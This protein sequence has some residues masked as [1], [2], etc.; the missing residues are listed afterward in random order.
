MS[1]REQ[2]GQM[3]REYRRDI[4]QLAKVQAELDAKVDQG[5]AALEKRLSKVEADFTSLDAAFL[6]I[7]LQFQGIRDEFGALVGE[8]RQIRADL[9]ESGRTV[10]GRLRLTEER[11][12]KMLDLVE[13]EL[14]D[15][16][17]EMLVRI[18]AL[19]GRLPPA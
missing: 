2:I 12:N 1:F 4:G 18:E 6:K 11:L 7:E 8:T 17:A 13:S 15:P 3:R 16:L 14:A 19:E 9:L 10:T 5:F